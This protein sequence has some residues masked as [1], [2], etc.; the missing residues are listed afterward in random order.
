MGSRARAT[1]LISVIMLAALLAAAPAARAGGFGMYGLGGAGGADWHNG[2]DDFGDVRDTTHAG[3][4]LVFDV[5]YPGTGVG[6]RLSFGWERV[7]QDGFYDAPGL[8]LEGGVVDQD[9]TLT[10]VGG[11]GPLRVWMGPE[12]RLGYMN[13]EW[14]GGGGTRTSSRPASGRSSASTSC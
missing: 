7:E 2:W 9:L 1:A 8:T 12:L 3:A 11:R 6:Y 5:A 14:G 10:L 4:G 13:G